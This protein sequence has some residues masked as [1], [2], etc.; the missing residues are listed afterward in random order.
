MQEVIT[1]SRLKLSLTI[2]L[3]GS[4]AALFSSCATDQPR[5]ALINDPDAQ[6]ES[7]IPWNKPA[8]WESGAN[9]PGGIGGA[10][11]GLTGSAPGQ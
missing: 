9:V 10:G 3:A 4:A 11:G 8:K 5:T 1:R 2:V 7:A 6:R